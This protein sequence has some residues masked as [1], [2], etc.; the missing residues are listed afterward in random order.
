MYDRF[1]A[2]ESLAYDLRKVHN[3]RTRVKTGKDDIELFSKDSGSGVWKMHVLPENLPK[4]EM[5]PS[6][7]VT[8]VC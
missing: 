7:I 3:K 8:E 6:K 1:R 5:K 4:F 2:V